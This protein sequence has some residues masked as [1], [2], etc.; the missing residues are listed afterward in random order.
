MKSEEK[1]ATTYHPGEPPGEPPGGAGALE[2]VDLESE[3]ESATTEIV[4]A[5]TA[6]AGDLV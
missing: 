3:N 6:A 5:E 1:S 4:K 2:S